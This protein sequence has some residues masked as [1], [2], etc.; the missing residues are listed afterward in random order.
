MKFEFSNKKVQKIM[1]DSNILKGK[2][3]LEIGKGIIKRLNQLESTNNFYE[4]LT[5]V[6][7]GKPHPLNGDLDTCYGIH[8]SAN[9]RL[10]VKPVT[11]SLDLE[12]LK[13]CEIIDIKGVLDYHGGKNEWIIP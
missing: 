1:E 9:Y 4:Y 11:N 2:V 12:S 5:C 3:G 8:V 13:K 10:V 6:G 7:L